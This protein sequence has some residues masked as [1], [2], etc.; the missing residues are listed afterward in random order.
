MQMRSNSSYD[1]L[2]D[3][4]TCVRL[5]EFQ[6][7]LY[8][9]T[10]LTKLYN[11]GFEWETIK[12]SVRSPIHEMCRNSENVSVFAS[13]LRPKFQVKTNRTQNNSDRTLKELS[14]GIQDDLI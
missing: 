13:H 3:E 7:I 9:T 1:S 11:F 14:N 6:V 8:Q 5:I 10:A 4:I 2:F 12:Q